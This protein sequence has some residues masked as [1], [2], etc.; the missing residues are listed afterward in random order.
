MLEEVWPELVAR[1]LG[2]Q[3]AGRDEGAS[4]DLQH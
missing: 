2:G 4:E 1:K 3:L